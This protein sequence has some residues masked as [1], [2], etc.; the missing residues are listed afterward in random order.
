MNIEELREY[1]LS[2]KGSEE[3]FPF[4]EDTLVFKVLGKMFA[5]TFLEPRDGQFAVNLKCDPE[6]AIELREKYSSV[7]PGYHANKKY[8]NTVYLNG[9]ASENEIQKW[10][11][12]SVEEVI[13]KLPKKLR[14]AYYE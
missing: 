8:W 13:K 6:K 5:Y 1:C 2:V 4:D 11:D 12:H 14:E 3:C 9:D 7:V 10:I